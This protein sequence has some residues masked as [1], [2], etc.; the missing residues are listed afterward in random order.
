MAHTRRISLIALIASLVLACAAPAGAETAAQAR[1]RQA[2]AKAKAADLAKK[3]DALRASDGD[4]D[5]A[6]KSISAEVQTQQARADAAHQALEAAEEQQQAA[7]AA[8]RDTA[9]KVA[10]VRTDVVQRAVASYIQ[11]QTGMSG[12]GKVLAGTDDLADISRR[13]TLLNEIAGRDRD[14]LDQLHGLQ[15]DLSHAQ[16][17]ADRAHALAD[18]RRKLEDQSLAELRQAASAKQRLQGALEARIR[19]YQ[20]DAHAVAKQE[21]ALTDLIRSKDAAERAS[22]ADGGASTGRISGAGLIW[23]ANGPVTSPF[24]SRWGRLHAGI[25]IGVGI[26]TP[27]HADKAG[28]VIYSSW[29]SG[30]GNVIIIDHGGGFSTLYGHQSRLVAGNGQYVTQGQ[31]IGY[32]GNTGESTGPHLHFETR[33]NGNPQNPRQYLP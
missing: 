25:D 5:Q 19:E 24:G 12:E 33:V 7:D 31:L 2:Q 14:T 23:P 4:L 18:Q 26:G 10:A 29:M 8:M 13:A 32:S 27:L 11:P 1:Q 16:A 3:I 28:T 15:S 21:T 30:Y 17:T 22:R 9:A 6:V 20:A